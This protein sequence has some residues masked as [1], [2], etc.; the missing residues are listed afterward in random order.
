[1]SSGY[2]RIVVYG[3]LG[4]HFAG[5]FEDMNQATHDGDTVLEGPFADQSH[6][7]GVF[8][9]LRSLGIEIRSFDT[10]RRGRQER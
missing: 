1:M 5:A 3:E 8:D 2:Y 9:Q 7:N 4:D 10:D 6:L